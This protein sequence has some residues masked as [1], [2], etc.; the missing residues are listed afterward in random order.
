M[1]PL[2][3][4]SVLFYFYVTTD[5]RGPIDQSPGEGRQL[6]SVV[7]GPPPLP[8]RVGVRGRRETAGSRR[9]TVPQ[10]I[11]DQFDLPRGPDSKKVLKCSRFSSPLLPVP[12]GSGRDHSHNKDDGPDGSSVRLFR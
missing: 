5:P 3:P 11:V 8:L 1:C 12:E 7:P 9:T 6:W 10:P 2:L 4:G